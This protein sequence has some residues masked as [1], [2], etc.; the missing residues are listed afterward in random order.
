MSA[1]CCS[2]SSSSMPQHT[3]VATPGPDAG[4]TH[5]VRT[6]PAIPMHH[7]TRSQRPTPTSHCHGDPQ[8]HPHARRAH[9]GTGRHS[10]MSVALPAARA[11]TGAPCWSTRGVPRRCGWALLRACTSWATWRRRA[12]RLS[13]CWRWTRTTRMRCWGWRSSSSRPPTCSRCASGGGGEGCERG[14]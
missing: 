14:V 9:A 4:R 5:T 13:A 7:H 1:G 2:S 6:P 8:Q 10:T 12:L 11:G 3:L